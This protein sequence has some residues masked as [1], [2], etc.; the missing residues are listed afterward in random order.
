MKIL[1]KIWE[2]SPQRDIA[3]LKDLVVTILFLGLFVWVWAGILSRAGP[4]L[5][6]GGFIVSFVGVL[7]LVL[8]WLP[9]WLSKR[10][11]QTRRE[12][13]RKLRLSFLFILGIVV[14]AYLIPERSVAWYWRVLLGVAGGTF[15]LMTR[16]FR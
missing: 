9:S 7:Y 10:T 8:E 16:R 5:L 4:L 1:R 2:G 3:G 13:E 12:V 14:G 15:A 11:G 6:F